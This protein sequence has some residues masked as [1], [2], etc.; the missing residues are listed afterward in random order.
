MTALTTL[1]L[2]IRKDVLIY[3]WTFSSRLCASPQILD[4]PPTSV[5]DADPEHAG[6]EG[7]VGDRHRG[8]GLGDQRGLPLE[9]ARHQEC[10]RLG[11]EPAVSAALRF[12]GRPKF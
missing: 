11:G 9:A 12:V 6:R 8:G 2:V 3:L 4:A 1:N 7:E 5:P 10:G